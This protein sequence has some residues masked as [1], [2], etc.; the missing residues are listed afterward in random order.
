MF[1]KLIK[2]HFLLASILCILYF[3]D[4]FVD[5]SNL[6]WILTQNE[7]LIKLPENNNP[8]Y[9]LYSNSINY[10]VYIFILFGFITIFAN[11][12]IILSKKHIK[13]SHLVY[14]I[15]WLSTFIVLNQLIFPDGFYAV[16]FWHLTHIVTLI[17]SL[18]FISRASDD[19]GFRNFKPFLQWKMSYKET[20]YHISFIC[21]IVLSNYLIQFLPIQDFSWRQESI[22]QDYASNYWMTFLIVVIIG[23]IAEELMFRGIIQQCLTRKFSVPIAIIVT[24]LLFSIFHIDIVK[25]LPLFAW[26]MYYSWLRFYYNS[27]W[28]S[29]FVHIIGNLIYTLYSS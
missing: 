27:I 29:V 17:I 9:L 4:W 14:S 8:Y 21:F 24:A 7:W 28:V 22:T 6:K 16:E 11:E 10:I 13:F 19:I 12:R 23:P 3:L 5:L 20:L 18:R 1:N 25:M 2:L 26:G 15:A